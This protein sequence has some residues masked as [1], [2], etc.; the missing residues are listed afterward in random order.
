MIKVG[1]E[2]EDIKI[3]KESCLSEIDRFFTDEEKDIISSHKIRNIAGRIAAKKAFFKSFGIEEDFK[4]IQIK[5][6]SSGKPFVEVID[7]NLKDLLKNSSIS[8]SIS[9]TED[10]AVAICIISQNGQ[11]LKEKK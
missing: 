3:I 5:K 6:T 4:K 9:H 2:I 7:E 1:I 10:V 8:I 11:N